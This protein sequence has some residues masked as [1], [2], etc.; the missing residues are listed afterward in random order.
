MK[1]LHGRQPKFLESSGPIIS[2][3]YVCTQKVHQNV[4][5]FLLNDL[6]GQLVMLRA[7]MHHITLS[8]TMYLL[9]SFKKPS[10]PQN[11]QLEI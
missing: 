2:F 10:P 1:Q 4:T 9:I 7:T 8:D 5:A 11:R 6:V 3:R